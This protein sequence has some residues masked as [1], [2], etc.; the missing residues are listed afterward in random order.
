M[1]PS[2]SH[3]ADA[4]PNSARVVIVEDEFIIANTLQTILADAGHQVVGTTTSAA[5]ALA[6]VAE[7]QP[8]LA[9]LDI[10]LGD[11]GGDDGLALAARLRDEHGTPFLFVSSYTD[12]ATLAA[13]KPLGPYGYIVK[14]F[15]DRD[16]VV[17]LELAL[18]KI[19]VDTFGREA[20]EKRVLLALSERVAAVRSEA[21][22]EDLVCSHVRPLLAFDALRLRTAVATVRFVAEDAGRC[23]VDY[24]GAEA[25]PAADYE[26]TA[27]A[28]LAHGNADLGH[29]EVHY[30]EAGALD[31]ERRSIVRGVASLL[32]IAIEGI[33]ATDRLLEEARLSSFGL[34]LGA[35][36]SEQLPWRERASRLLDPAFAFL[37]YDVLLVSGG[38]A[39]AT[40]LPFEVAHRTS[41]TDTTLLGHAEVSRLL[42][43]GG[44]ERPPS[45][46]AAGSS[47]PLIVSRAA[48]GF[49]QNDSY[50][51]RLLSHYQLAQAAVFRVPLREYPGAYVAFLTRW[52]DGYTSEHL[53]PRA[54][55][56]HSLAPQLDSAFAYAR[57]AQ[58]TRQLERERLYL[59]DEVSEGY[60]AKFIIGRSP[61]MQTAL[62]QVAQVAPTDTT[63]LVTGET[64]TGKELIA[65]AVHE[66]SRRAERTLIKVNCAALPANLIESELF[67]HERGAF[68]GATARRLGKFELA[69]DSTIFLDEIGEIPL[70]LQTKLLRVL[71]EKEFERVGGSEVIRAEFRVVAAT[72]RDLLAEVEGGRFRQDLFYRLHV[73]PIH[74]PPLRERPSDIPELAEFFLRKYARKQGKPARALSQVSLRWLTQYPFPGNVRELEHL[75]ERALITS[76][77]PTLS[78]DAAVLPKGKAPEHDDGPYVEQTL[79][80]HE[81]EHILRTLAHTDGRIRGVRGAAELLDIKPTTLEA[82]MK[83]LG[84]VKGFR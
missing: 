31:R 44:D 38:P 56:I 39:T 57:I 73:F 48:A 54:A 66:G 4:L 55:M 10:H 69:R 19:Q 26:A 76:T 14:P 27:H 43:L 74:L 7:R 36:L 22:L 41:R 59:R 70:E 16:V 33:R 2:T 3:A 81:R 25:E 67:G 65:R 46:L 53:P 84:I 63:V 58:L 78:I 60:Q 35:A 83:R 12:A 20:R 62:A 18:H 32:A 6:L 75:I 77:S 28:K 5:A 52:D 29:V 49:R 9:L 21:D 13:A 8:D 64:G 37:K 61:G 80:D 47:E 17:A 71:Q 68:T 23:A 45:P 50:V 30:R 1:L 42:R 34:A 11:D 51:H 15:T 40:D 72:N 24:E 82:R 79:A